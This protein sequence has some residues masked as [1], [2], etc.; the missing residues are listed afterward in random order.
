MK[1]PNLSTSHVSA[2]SQGTTNMALVLN[3]RCFYAPAIMCQ[4][5]FNMLIVIICARRKCVVDSE[6]TFEYRFYCWCAWIKILRPLNNVQILKINKVLH[7]EHTK[8]HSYFLTPYSN[9]LGCKTW[10]LTQFFKENVHFYSCHPCVTPPVAEGSVKQIV[11]ALLAW[12]PLIVCKWKVNQEQIQWR[13]Q[14]VKPRICFT[15]TILKCKPWTIFECVHL[16]WFN[17]KGQHLARVKIQGPCQV[18]GDVTIAKYGVPRR[19]MVVPGIQETTLSDGCTMHG[20]S[21]ETWSW[22]IRHE[23]IIRRTAHT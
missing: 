19:V 1:K 20:T 21:E 11:E 5:C 18:V 15:G 17:L 14:G 22:Y 9:L 13:G 23:V 16:V 2:S 8:L 10:S 3:I 12:L 4:Q 6:Q 7:T